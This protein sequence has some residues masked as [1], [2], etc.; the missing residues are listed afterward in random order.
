MGV[1]QRLHLLPR[2]WVERGRGGGSGQREAAPSPS[3]W[4]C[5]RLRNL[6]GC[7][8]V[9]VGG[10][11]GR[12]PELRRGAATRVNVL[13]IQG[14][15]GGG[16]SPLVPQGSPWPGSGL[17]GLGGL[18]LT[19]SGFQPS[20]SGGV[21]SARAPLISCLCLHARCC[22]PGTSRPMCTLVPHPEGTQTCGCSLFTVGRMQLEATYQ[23][24]AVST[25]TNPG[26]RRGPGR[27]G[28]DVC[29]RNTGNPGC[30][31]CCVVDCRAN[32]QKVPGN[33]E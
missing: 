4:P 3:G 6:G 20:L 11:A 25:Q 27:G 15:E 1:T 17:K 12:R 19:S 18:H 21:T 23:N 28:C 29:L 10:R 24:H 16:T 26:Q 8:H 32:V 14:Q 33:P 13:G 9:A 5:R 7:I 2:R 31:W 22:F 30:P